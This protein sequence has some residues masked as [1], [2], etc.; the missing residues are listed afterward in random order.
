MTFI[1]FVSGVLGLLSLALG[2]GIAVRFI[3]MWNDPYP[4]LAAA[5]VVFGIYSVGSACYVLD[6]SFN[7][8]KS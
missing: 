5:F 1:Y 6:K 4:A 2:V 3:A 7:G 8:G